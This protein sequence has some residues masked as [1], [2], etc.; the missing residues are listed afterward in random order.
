MMSCLR[1]LSQRAI[2]RTRLRCSFDGISRRIHRRHKLLS[3]IEENN[4][5]PVSVVR[6]P[7]HYS[8]DQY[9]ARHLWCRT[10]SCAPQHRS[11]REFSS[12]RS[13]LL[14]TDDL[15]QNYIRQIVAEWNQIQKHLTSSESDSGRLSAQRLHFLEPIVCKVQ[16]HEQ[17]SGDISELEDIISGMCIFHCSL[18]NYFSFVQNQP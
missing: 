12:S 5:L 8:T 15:L 4:Y 13:P 2:W 9:H 3:N 1:I 16:Q 11:V 6:Y 17:F 7:V 18:F 10:K 14:F